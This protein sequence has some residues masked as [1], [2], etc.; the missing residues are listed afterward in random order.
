MLLALL[1][2]DGY[3]QDQP[4]LLLDLVQGRDI[5]A[6]MRTSRYAFFAVLSRW[7]G[8][9]NTSLIDFLRVILPNARCKKPFSDESESD[10]PF[11][12]RAL[13]VLYPNHSLT[14]DLYTLDLGDFSPS[15]YWR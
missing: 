13:N 11:L 2:L 9:H 4:S 12:V 3:N 14:A 15:S 7:T 8:W 6:L 5:A 1:A 10:S